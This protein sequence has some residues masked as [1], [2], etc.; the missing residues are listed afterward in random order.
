MRKHQ[1]DTASDIKYRQAHRGA[2]Q[3][4]GGRVFSPQRDPLIHVT[5]RIGDTSLADGWTSASDSPATSRPFQNSH[6]LLQLQRLYGNSYVQRLLA[7]ASQDDSS[8]HAPPDVEKA[9]HRARGGGH[10]MDSVLRAQMENTFG[11][12]FSSLRVHTDA[13]A[14]TLSRALNARAF[15][16][17]QDIF[18]RQG[19]YNPGSSSGRHLLAHELSH[20]VQQGA[21]GLKRKLTVSQPGDR[22]EREADQVA[23]EVT[24]REQRAA[25]KAA[26]DG[27][28]LRQAEEEEEMVQAKVENASA[29][30]QMEEE[31]GLVQTLLVWRQEAPT[32]EAGTAEAEPTEAEKAA[33]AAAAAAAEGVAAQATAVGKSETNKSKAAQATER[34]A[35]Q[36]AKQEA[37]SATAAGPAKAEAEGVGQAP[38][39][40]TGRA[41]GSAAAKGAGPGVN[42]K[43]PASA[44]EDPAFQAV[45]GNIEG[46]ATTEQTHAPAEAKAGEA[47]AAAVSPPKEL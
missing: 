27:L 22:Y 10:A 14:D 45:I 34:E 19:A 38:A 43:A 40:E 36:A 23:R 28:A 46:V 4:I 6:P 13:R 31:E 39:E 42:G 17:G 41:T 30:R 21:G 18:F 37:A 25:P 3:K 44:E 8:G 33:A 15:T 12:D 32:A 16:T 9:I 35:G 29:Q 26:G 2:L 1:L 7:R 24:Q 20:V 5:D 11:S 47:Q